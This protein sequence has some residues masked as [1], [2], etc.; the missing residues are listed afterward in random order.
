MP[1]FAFTL[2]DLPHVNAL[3]NGL[4]TALLLVG[5]ALIKNRRERAHRNVMLSAFAVSTAFLTCYLVYHFGVDLAKK[6][7]GGPPLSYV[8][9]AILLSH[10]LLAMTVPVLAITTIYLGLKDRRARHLRWARWTFPIW[11]YVSVTGVVI[12]LM[13]YQLYPPGR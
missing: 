13:L 2:N 5:Y 10:V 12:Y 4:A 1:L 3:L 6:F 9:Y 7:P 8:Y 11:L